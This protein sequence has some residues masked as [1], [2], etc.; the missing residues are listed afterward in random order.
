MAGGGV[1]IAL[2]PSIVWV[3]GHISLLSIA[4]GLLAVLILVTKLS[5]TEK[6]REIEEN[7]SHPHARQVSCNGKYPLATC[8]I[9]VPQVLSVHV[10][11]INKTWST[12]ENLMTQIFLL[13]QHVSTPPCTHVE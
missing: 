10:P 7:L 9:G 4:W 11:I 3:R 5:R 12:C 13:S 6:L 1:W 2:P 8:M